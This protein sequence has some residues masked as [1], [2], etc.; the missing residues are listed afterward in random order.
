MAKKSQEPPDGDTEGQEDEGEDGLTREGVL[1]MVN[2][3]VASQLTRKLGPALKQAMQPLQDQL[4]GVLEQP[5][6]SPKPDATDSGP[7]SKYDAMTNRIK[8]LEAQVKDEREKQRAADERNRQ[9]RLEN[10]L[11]TELTKANVRPELLPGAVSVL[12]AK[13]THG[14]DGEPV[15]RADRGGYHEDLSVAAGIEE[16]AATDVGKAHLSPRTVQGSGQGR[17]GLNSTSRKPAPAPADPKQAKRQRIRQA[18]A[19]LVSGVREMLSA[20]ASIDLTGPT[21]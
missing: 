14:E 19:D 1:R 17:V 13:V 21:E 11:R 5:T 2:A 15:W 6:S 12:K 8:A 9:I 10:S 16:W 20:G 18:R 4:A 7:D 3:A